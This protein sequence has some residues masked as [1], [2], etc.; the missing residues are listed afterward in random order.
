MIEKALK[1]TLKSQG[2]TDPDFEFS[3]FELKN[4]PKKIK[5]IEQTDFIIIPGCTTLSIDDYKGLKEIMAKTTKPI[6]NIGPAFFKHPDEKFISF[7]KNVFKPLGVRDPF[8]LKYLQDHELE[9]ELIGCPTLLLGNATEFELRANN[10][11]LFCFGLENIEEQIKLIKEITASSY[12]ITIMI[13][14][15]YQLDYVKDLDAKI[16]DYSPDSLLRELS[17]TRLVVTGRLHVALPA[18]TVGTPVFFIETIQDCRFSLIDFLAIKKFAANDKN[19]VQYCKKQLK[20]FE[21]NN[22]KFVYNQVKKL[23]KRFL[24]YIRLIKKHIN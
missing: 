2:F 9:S 24:N 5:R 20:S 1:D 15:N 17:D 22:E 21:F 8:S 11:V 19:L 7:S 3:A 6:F 10:K 16:V 18:I 14:A 4:L 23:R 12:S 13:Q